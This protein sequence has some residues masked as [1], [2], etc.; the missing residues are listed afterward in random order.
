MKSKFRIYSKFES[1]VILDTT[2]TMKEV[3]MCASMFESY[4]ILDIANW[5][6]RTERGA[7]FGELFFKVKYDWTTIWQEF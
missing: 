1:Y 3:F 6:K 5:K 7:F 2:K 4:V